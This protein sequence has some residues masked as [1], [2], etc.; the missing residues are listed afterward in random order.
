MQG[1]PLYP[2]ANAFSKKAENH[3]HAVSLY[4]MFYNYRR[5]HQ[6]LTRAAKAIT[7]T[8]AMAAGIADHVW[9]VEEILSKMD[10]KTLLQ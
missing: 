2:P 5:S 7:T 3:A 10:P 9:P 8:R 6:T 4:F 1:A